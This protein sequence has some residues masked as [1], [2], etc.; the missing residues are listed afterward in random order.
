MAEVHEGIEDVVRELRCLLRAVTRGTIGGVR[1]SRIALANLRFPSSPEESVVLAERAIADA[2]SAG[3]GLV[4]F[5]EAYVPG[6]RIGKDIAAPD[7]TFL[8]EAWSAVGAA[9]A[10]AK[11]TVVL[12]TERV[13]AGTRRLTALVVD[14]SGK[15]LGF[16]DKVQLDPSEDA[17]FSPGEERR[18]FDAG[19]LRFGVVICHEGF[20]YPETVRWAAR[21]GARLVLH[22]HFD[23]AS[24][25]SFRP[26]RFADPENTFHEKAM[27]C[28]AAENTC[29]FASVNCASDGSPTTS[30][31]MRPDGT[32][33]AY[34][35]YGREGLLI[36]DI[37]L[38]AATR[39]LATRCRS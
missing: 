3:A 16:Q 25:G 8:A 31:V 36:A 10:R 37:D 9:A 14:P 4:C 15:T 34:Q 2:G 20:R 32:L 27:L 29:W 26:Q 12:G 19:D 21:N 5:P 11:V 6:Y 22:P 23:E 1:T 35:P 18:V 17:T 7:P 24:P 13:V 28:R 39:I 30:A 38:D 33:H